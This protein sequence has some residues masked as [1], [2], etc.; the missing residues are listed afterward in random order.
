VVAH[1]VAAT[2]FQA[3]GIV[4]SIAALK[5]ASDVRVRVRVRVMASSSVR[6]DTLATSR[7]C[8]CL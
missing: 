2:L 1:V 8:C 7:D 3:F 5:V 6:L 4:Y